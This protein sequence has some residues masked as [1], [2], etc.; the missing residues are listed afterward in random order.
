MQF[1]LEFLSLFR[2]ESNFTNVLIS[3]GDHMN[4]AY[5]LYVNAV[6]DMKTQ[7]LFNKEFAAQLV[8]FA[9]ETVIIHF[10]GLKTTIKLCDCDMEKGRPKKTVV[11]LVD[12]F[13]A[14]MPPDY[15][16]FFMFL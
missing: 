14:D 6:A 4:C 7:L 11:R 10:L 8:L 13:P 16:I 9:A 5:W 1:V 15:S 2:L 12:T 3:G